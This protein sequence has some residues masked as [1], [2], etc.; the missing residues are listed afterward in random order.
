MENVSPSRDE[1]QCD[2]LAYTRAHI[3]FHIQDM[4]KGDSSPANVFSC[5]TL[6]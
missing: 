4:G 3:V 2:S 6:D 1:K 5:V